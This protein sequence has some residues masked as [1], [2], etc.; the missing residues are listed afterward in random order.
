VQP[1]RLTAWLGR[2][3]VPVFYALAL[4]TALGLS[5]FFFSPRLVLFDRPRPGTFEW[6]RALTYLKQC[7][8]PFRR[9]LEDDRAMAWRF[10]P[11]LVAYG[12]GLRGTAA[13]TVPWV[14]VVVLLAYAC[15]LLLKY[16]GSR[17][18]ALAGTGLVATTSAVFVPAQWLGINDAWA[19]AGLLGVALGGGPGTVFLCCLLCP[20]VDERFLVGLPLAV[21]CRH[22][23]S[24]SEKGPR[25][26]R[27]EV[28]AA[29]VGVLPYAAIRAYA[30]FA[31]TDDPTGGFLRATL[32]GCKVW[33]PWAHMGWWMGYR[34]AWVF[35]VYY[36]Y[37]V[38]REQ[39]AGV[40]AAG[41]LLLLATAA[42]VTVLAADTSRSSALAL[43]LVVLGLLEL[44]RS[45]PALGVRA[46]WFGLAVNLLLPAAHVTYTK[47]YLINPLPLE[48]YRVFRG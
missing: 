23:A 19:T 22:L 30:V 32:A 35:I 17:S 4:A 37:R 7:E 16:T 38:W 47:F 20:W 14:G 42:V 39:G 27:P 36:L 31:R 15:R 11:P 29:A 9:D 18:L 12:L 41:A 34:A 43:P 24:A 8:A 28:L 45:D 25:V 40:G 13:F 5:L 6:S 21:Y 48:L 10:L 3:P 1:G 46:G 2:I 33:A 44:Y 26:G